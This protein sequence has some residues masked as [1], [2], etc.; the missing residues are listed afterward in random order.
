MW[1]IAQKSGVCLLWR[2]LSRHRQGWVFRSY[3]LGLTFEAAHRLQGVHIPTRG[4]TSSTLTKGSISHLQFCPLCIHCLQITDQ[5]KGEFRWQSPEVIS[6]PFLSFTCVKTHL[7]ILL[8]LI[9]TLAIH[10]CLS[11]LV[12]IAW[13]EYHLNQAGDLCINGFWWDQNHLDAGNIY[14]LVHHR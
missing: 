11:V 8:I 14:R 1:N 6:F 7:Y 10:A 5:L 3:L 9:F 4:N 12:C 2:R 13:T